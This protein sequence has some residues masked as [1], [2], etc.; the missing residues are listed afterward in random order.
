MSEPTPGR[1]DHGGQ[2]GAGRGRGRSRYYRGYRGP[3]R[4]YRG[5]RTTTTTVFKGE[6]KEMNGNVFQTHAERDK[7]G[8]FQ[9]TLT[10][11][12]LL[13]STEFKKDLIH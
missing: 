9:D 2:D 3:R 7:P 6:S 1:G 4:Q 8:Q 11:L 13:A 5:A 10:A 12:K